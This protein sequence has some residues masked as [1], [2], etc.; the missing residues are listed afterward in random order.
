[1]PTP[2][3]DSYVSD[4]ANPVPYRH[5]PIR[6]NRRMDHVARR[7]SALRPAA[8]G[9]ADWVSEP[10]ATDLTISGRIVAHL[11]AAS[12]GT[13]SD[14]VVKLIDVYPEKYEPDPEMGGYQLMIAGDVLRARYRRGFEKPAPMT[15]NAVEHYQIGVSRPTIMSSGRGIGSWCRCRARGSRSSTAIPSVRAEYLPRAAVGFPC[16]HP[17]SV[18]LGLA[19]I[20]HRPSDR[21]RE[22]RAALTIAHSAS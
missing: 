6:L 1:M 9:R 5:R 18:P 11:F 10:L 13:D 15:P 14:W 3:F 2:A 16:G 20:V 8:A 4:P 22:P 19:G 17:A 12:S 7:G 21:E